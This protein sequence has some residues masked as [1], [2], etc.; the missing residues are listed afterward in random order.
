MIRI[1][2]AGA[3]ESKATRACT[4]GRRPHTRCCANARGSDQ[5]GIAAVPAGSARRPRPPPNEP[6]KRN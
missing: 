5:F 3:R 1:I 2:S 6:D 4:W